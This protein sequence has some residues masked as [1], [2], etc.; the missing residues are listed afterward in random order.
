MKKIWYLLKCPRG[1]EADYVKSC[2]EAVKFNEPNGLQEVIYFQYHRM[3][4]YRGQWHLEKRAVLP[5]YIFVF[6]AEEAVSEHQTRVRSE[7]KEIFM[8][9]CETPYLKDLCP[10][11]D[12]VGM[13]GGIIKDG[14]PVIT[15]GPLLGR[16]KL[17]RRIDRH[18]RTAEIGI[19][20]EGREQ[21]V[22]V[23]LEIYEKQ[24]SSGKYKQD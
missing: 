11:G 19:P 17:I 21:R 12:L 10:E 20:L 6:G 1:N 15:S 2:Q 18:R 13:S 22:T 3:I 9:Q 16:E 23:G 14:V 8:N 4:R 5:G 24:V 7:N